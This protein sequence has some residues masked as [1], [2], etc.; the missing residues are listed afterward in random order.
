LE[1][2]EV[3][4]GSCAGETYIGTCTS[5]ASPWRARSRQCWTSVLKLCCPPTETELFR[6]ICTA[7]VHPARVRPSRSRPQRPHCAMGSRLR[8]P[9]RSRRGMQPAHPVAPA[10]PT[11]ATTARPASYPVS[12]VIQPSWPPNPPSPAG[13]RT[14]PAAITRRSHDP[15]TCPQDVRGLRDKQAAVGH[16][17]KPRSQRGLL[18]IAGHTRHI[19]VVPYRHSGDRSQLAPR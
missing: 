16:R 9:A 15:P 13:R 14:T 7:P 17:A 3:T 6:A 2:G 12:S 8:E 5:E 4:G 10:A 18:A 1:R 11:S 19:L